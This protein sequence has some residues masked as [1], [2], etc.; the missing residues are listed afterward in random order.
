MELA[1]SFKRLVPLLA[2]GL[3]ASAGAQAAAVTWTDYINFDPDVKVTEFRP[4]TYTHDI[5]DSGFNPGDDWVSDYSLSLNL[6][7]DQAY[8]GGETA[9]VNLP[10]LSGDKE[11]FNLGGTEYGGW[12]LLGFW[13]ILTEGKLS[14]SIFAEEGDFYIGDSTLTVKGYSNSVPEPA[15]L[16]LLGTCL[17]GLGLLRRKRAADIVG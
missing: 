2:I 5:T 9:Y 7:D 6:Y 12:S 10:G 4:F 3:L 8:D 17:L 16:A 11:F 14:V 1:M 13:Q 15:S